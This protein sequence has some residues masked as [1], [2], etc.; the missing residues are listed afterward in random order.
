[1]S[2]A[3]QIPDSDDIPESDDTIPASRLMRERNDYRDSHALELTRANELEKRLRKVEADLA[4]WQAIALRNGELL[5]HAEVERA[6][7][8]GQVI[9]LADKN[10]NDWITFQNDN[11]EHM[12]VR[13]AY[14]ARAD[15][16]A[17]F[18]ETVC[19]DNGWTADDEFIEDLILSAGVECPAC[20]GRGYDEDE[21]MVPF[22]GQSNGYA[23]R[24]VRFDCEKCHGL[25]MVLR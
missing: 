12:R 11:A 15:K 8:Q 21:E 9:H 5:A 14:F 20:E 16:L 6:S 23:T 25:K 22:G 19:E 3:N 4:D 10:R 2:T 7:A 13:A 1:M 17:A 18:I 24:E